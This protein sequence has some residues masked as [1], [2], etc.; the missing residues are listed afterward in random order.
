VEAGK[1]YQKTKSTSAGRIAK[2]FFIP[3][4]EEGIK[5]T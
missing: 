3:F 4:F 1:G 2:R 5:P